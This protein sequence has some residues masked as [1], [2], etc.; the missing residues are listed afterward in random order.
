MR[1]EFAAIKQDLNDGALVNRALQLCT[2]HG[3]SPSD[4]AIKWESFL[5]NEKVGQSSTP[6]SVLMTRFEEWLKANAVARPSKPARRA[7]AGARTTD[8][9]L[10]QGPLR[11]VA[12]RSSTQGKGEG[13]GEVAGATMRL[14]QAAGSSTVPP[15][16][17]QAALERRAPSGKVEAHLLPDAALPLSSSGEETVGE[18]GGEVPRAGQ[19]GE[20]AAAAEVEVV[21]V[22]DS[23][24]GYPYR[25]QSDKAVART[26]AFDDALTRTGERLAERFGFPGMGS[27][28]VHGEKLYCVARVCVKAGSGESSIDELGVYVQSTVGSGQPRTR[29]DLRT[30]DSCSLFPGQ[31]IGVE[32]SNLDGKK[33]VAQRLFDDARPLR[34][35]SIFAP[36]PSTHLKALV[37]A[38]PYTVATSKDWSYQSSAL[39]AIVEVAKVHAV[40]AVILFGPF[41]DAQIWESGSL[42]VPD[43]PFEVLFEKNLLRPLRASLSSLRSTPELILVPS[44][45]DAHHHTV[46]P[47]PPYDTSGGKQRGLHLVANPSLVRINGL[48]LGLTS[49]D[50]L[51]DIARQELVKG[52][53]LEERHPARLAG[54]LLKQGSFYP[55]HPPAPGVPLDSTQLFKTELPYVPDVLVVPSCLSPFARVVEGAACVN[56][57]F[58]VDGAAYGTAALLTLHRASVATTTTVERL[59]VKVLRL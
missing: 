20:E 29:L 9:E 19:G 16:G 44:L 27:M 49:H 42:G 40:H 3:Q 59:E 43:T 56:P 15:P 57:G 34:S 25:Y 33:L 51:A 58:A 55:V 18:G 36:P 23:T 35:P 50:V 39:P 53:H 10:L 8:R 47:Q 1:R 48:A 24:G 4:L 12:A 31:V 2:I 54:H 14:S 52:D 30:I 28:H 21:V 7:F 13:E 5:I 38:G 11:E 45:R 41:V 22:G 26:H 37:A 32:G 46:Y 17:G 6:T